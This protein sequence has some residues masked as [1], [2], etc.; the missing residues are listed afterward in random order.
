MNTISKLKR[1]ALVSFVII[2]LSM[3]GCS[4]YFSNPLENKETGE[5]INLVILDFN[6]FHTRMTYK[7]VDAKTSEI[8]K[9][10]ATVQ[11]SGK[12]GND[13]VSYTGE[14]NEKY[15]T[16]E[17]QLELTID[18]NINISAG[19]AFEFS[20][21]VDIEGYNS[22]SKGFILNSEG[23]KTFE[24]SLSKKTDEEDSDLNGDVDFGDGDT[25][26]HFMAPAVGLKS[27]RVETPY[28]IDHSFTLDDLMKFRDK[29]GAPLFSSKTEAFK[30]YSNDPE[31][32]HQGFGI[33]IY[34][35]SGR[36]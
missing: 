18:P 1:L 25:V 9:V 5:D 12:N 15:E 34:K 6:F 29:T 14:K 32:F 35:L 24:L 4:D 22:L 30:A 13:I 19:S 28:K 26:F 16:S 3:S 33:K 36:S 10:N 11:F 8:I 27:L 31:K 7:L 20:V 23:I 17:G 2:L 21:N